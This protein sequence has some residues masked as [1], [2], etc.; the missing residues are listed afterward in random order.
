[1]FKH[2]LSL[3]QIIVFLQIPQ[4][5]GNCA[6]LAFMAQISNIPARVKAINIRSWM[7]VFLLENETEIM[8]MNKNF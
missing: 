4:N 1:M 2:V 8:V 5:R 7:V 3:Q 6:I